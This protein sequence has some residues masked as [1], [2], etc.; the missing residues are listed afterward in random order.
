M[1]KLLALTLLLSSAAFAAETR[2]T[3]AQCQTLLADNTS[4]DI[5]PQDLRDCLIATSLS[6][7][8]NAQT[9][10]T[11]TFVALDRA[12][13]V[14][15]SNAASIAVTLPQAGTSGFEDGWWVYVR[16][17]GAG[18]ATI[19]PTTSTID[20][21][22]SVAL[23]SGAYALIFSDGTNYYSVASVLY[24]S[25]VVDRD[26]IGTTT[27]PGFSLRNDTAATAGN[28]QYAPAVVWESQI[29]DAGGAASSEIKWFMEGIGGQ[30][31][32]SEAGIKPNFRLSY[33]IDGGT[34]V[35]WFYAYNHEDGYDGDMNTQNLFWG[36]DS[37]NPSGM[38]SAAMSNIGIGW[39][40]LT[41]CTGCN[42]NFAL[43]HQ[44]LK[45]LTTGYW[46]TAVGTEAG[47]LMS[48]GYQNVCIGQDACRSPSLSRAVRT[49]AQ[50]TFLGVQS[51]PATPQQNNGMIAIGYQAQID[52][53]GSGALG[54]DG[55]E[56]SAGG[57][58]YPD[59]TLVVA[60]SSSL[61][62][63]VLSETDFAT[64]AD[65]DVTG[66][67]DDSGGNC[68]Y[69]HSAGSGSCQQVAADHATAVI[70][71]ALYR[72]QFTVS[73]F[74]GDPVC[75]IQ[76]VLSVSRS[77]AE[78]DD[79]FYGYVNDTWYIDFRAD[80]SNADFTISCTSD[81]GDDTVAFDN[82]SIKPITDGDLEI[83]DDQFVWGNPGWYSDTAYLATLDH[84]NTASRTYSAFD[85]DMNLV[86]ATDDISATG[87]TAAITTTNLVASAAAG[88]YR[89]SGY[90]HTT[91]AADGVCTS[92]I[93]IGWT[94]D[95]SAESGETVSNHDQNV[96]NTN[97][98]F[99][100]VLA[101]DASANITYA[102][103]LDAGGDCTNAEF[104]AFIVAER[105]Q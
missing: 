91:T 38:T 67:F 94:Y 43:G 71:N 80:S 42:E 105:I 76:D 74:A 37:G 8:I 9:G 3:Y 90:L 36:V 81:S 20:A 2:Q 63:E 77:M 57:Y 95:S 32:S 87:Q 101:S 29:W 84:A 70:P 79:Y 61:G 93:T 22:A 18:T 82:I 33:Q 17:T 47:I 100:L 15:L 11:Y 21:Q 25:W 28:Q 48:T 44:S 53:A 102:V 41:S 85:D 50:N 6:R 83:A 7:P 104:D 13:L 73:G 69:T 23:D 5:S 78:W 58:R 55:M 26:G 16:V 46:N 12:K 10:T 99:S 31:G 103:S 86:G 59:K 49:A 40:T 52:R 92:D 39:N 14:T 65:W 60:D 54:S 51:G 62:S 75:T 56:W 66:D 27:T 72:L 1:R 4:G 98:Q 34:V 19:T 96:D 24:G 45:D 97:S 68:L 35:P 64:H 30:Q 89:I 88:L